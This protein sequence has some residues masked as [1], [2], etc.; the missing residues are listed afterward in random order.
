MG[1]VFGT[2]VN[3]AVGAHVIKKTTEM[4]PKKKRRC[5]HE[6]KKAYSSRL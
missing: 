1:N 4:K 5:K 3:V 6:K 2:L